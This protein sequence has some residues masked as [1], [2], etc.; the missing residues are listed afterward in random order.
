MSLFLN[1][2]IPDHRNQM[3]FSIQDNKELAKPTERAKKIM[4]IL[5]KL[6]HYGRPNMM[7]NDDGREFNHLH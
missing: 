1:D 6:S 2:L 5:T 4:T 3:F 7:V